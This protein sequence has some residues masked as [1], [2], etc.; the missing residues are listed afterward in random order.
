[1]QKSE[2]KIEKNV[3]YID[4]A[5]NDVLVRSRKSRR[6]SLDCSKDPM[7]TEQQHL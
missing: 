2:K 6:V 3:E 5:G 4:A 1:M 7:I